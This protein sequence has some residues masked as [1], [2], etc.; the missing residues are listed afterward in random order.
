[1]PV[2]TPDLDVTDVLDDPDFRDDTLQVKRAVVL[3]ADDGTADESAGWTNFSGVVHPAG[4]DDLVQTPEGDSVTGD[5]VIITRF[6]LSAGDGEM[7]ADIVAYQ[8]ANHRVRNAKDWRYG[9]GFTEA[10]C[11]LMPA[12]PTSLIERDGCGYLG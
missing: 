1:M 9:Q 8:G 11:T 5:I 4:G 2:H 12:N 3:Q 10:V 6:P 7:G